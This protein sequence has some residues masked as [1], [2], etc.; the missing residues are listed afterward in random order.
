MP[1]PC[2]AHAWLGCVFATGFPLCFASLAVVFSLGT[3][4]I[5][6]SC[7]LLS[8]VRTNDGSVTVHAQRP[9]GTS[10]S[11]AAVHVASGR[12]LTPCTAAGRPGPSMPPPSR[13]LAASIGSFGCMQRLSAARLLAG[14]W[15]R[16]KQ[17]R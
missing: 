12:W 6:Q 1:R 14:I 2:R 10:A 15:E 16:G 13:V 7:L 5:T 3:C 9:M 8:V 17:L 11:R 4:L